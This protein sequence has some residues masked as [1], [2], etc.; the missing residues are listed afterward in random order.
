MLEFRGRA[1]PK[2]VWRAHVG[3]ILPSE[4]PLP[5]TET[6][7]RSL[8]L[9]GLL[10]AHVGHAVLLLCPGGS[11][12]LKCSVLQRVCR[13]VRHPPVLGVLAGLDSRE[14]VVA[15]PLP[16]D[17]CPRHAVHRN[18]VYRRG[19]LPRGRGELGAVSCGCASL[20]LV[21]HVISFCADS[22]IL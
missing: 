16:E 15:G 22:R 1:M 11:R 2:G 5:T 4:G 7:G 12:G 14:A 8:P 17:C 19:H 3:R 13:G 10:L 6:R 18:S 21:P 20:V 9:C